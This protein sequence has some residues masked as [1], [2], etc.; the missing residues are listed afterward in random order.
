[1][2][3]KP[4]RPSSA[5]S[6][7][8]VVQHMDTQ[9]TVAWSDGLFAGNPNELKQTSRDLYDS[10][11]EVTLGGGRTLRIEHNAQGAALAM[12]AACGGRGRIISTSHG[13]LPSDTRTV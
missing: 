7:V 2:S 9:E 10:H 6:E 8:V 5:M 11:A 12:I 4:G 3:R 1:M 13:V